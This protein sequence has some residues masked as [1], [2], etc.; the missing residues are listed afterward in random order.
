VEPASAQLSFRS[1]AS[2]AIPA[3]ADE[4]DGVLRLQRREADAIRVFFERFWEP[5]VRAAL[6]I[7]HSH[8]GAEDVAQDSLLRALDRI[9]RFDS[10]RPLAPWVH[11]IVVNCS[12]DWIRRES[13]TVS[14]NQRVESSYEDSASFDQ[15][16]IEAMKSLAPDQR[17]A[18]VMRHLFGYRAN[19]I[20]DLLGVP[21]GTV[22]ARLSRGLAQLRETLEET[23]ALD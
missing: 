6:L 12:I 10:T 17:S 9:D 5:S 21:H 2:T 8:A 20:A 16:L 23:N 13:R 15:G 7:V 18:I 11:A 22:R 14:A 4:G 3:Q 1:Y 19:E